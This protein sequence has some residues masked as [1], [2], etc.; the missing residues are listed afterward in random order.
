MENARVHLNQ[1]H[2]KS[3]QQLGCCK[4]GTKQGQGRGMTSVLEVRYGGKA[5]GQSAHIGER[6]LVLLRRGLHSVVDASVSFRLLTNKTRGEGDR[7]SLPL[8]VPLGLHLLKH[9]PSPKSTDERV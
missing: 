2:A 7:V 8:S 3:P 6:A 4:G 9:P 1:P 5:L